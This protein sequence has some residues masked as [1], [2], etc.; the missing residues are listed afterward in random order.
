MSVAFPTGYY[1]TKSST[2]EIDSG[3]VHDRMDDGSMRARVLADSVYSTIR[4]V[5]P[6]LTQSEANTLVDFFAT[7]RAEEI[8]MTVDGVAYIGRITSSVQK[9]MRG[10]RYGITFD[11]YAKES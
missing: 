7:N 9:T 3:V 8:T 10:N 5:V 2:F 6:M 11:Y 1:L 4:C